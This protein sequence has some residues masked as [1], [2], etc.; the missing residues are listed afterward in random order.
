MQPF[1]ALDFET[2]NGKRAS[3]CS[4]GLAK[5][6]DNGQLAG[7]FHSLIKPHPE[8]SFFQP[9]NIWVHGIRPDDVADAPEWGTSI[10]K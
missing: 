9:A 1:V 2:A 8:H 10:P 5:F 6:D 3:A 4:V 7:T